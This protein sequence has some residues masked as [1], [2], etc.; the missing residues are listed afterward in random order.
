MTR[1]GIGWA[2]RAALAALLLL[3]AGGTAAGCAHR[4]HREREPRLQPEQGPVETRRSGIVVHT[5][6]VKSQFP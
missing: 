1:R 4:L 3:G 6:T 5:K 2:A